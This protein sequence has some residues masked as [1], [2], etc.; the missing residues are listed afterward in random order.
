MKMSAFL[1]ALVCPLSLLVLTSFAT[2]G[3]TTITQTYYWRSAANTGERAGLAA[4]NAWLK[5]N[6]PK[7]GFQRSKLIALD[8]TSNLN[9]EGS[10]I[11]LLKFA[12]GSGEDVIWTHPDSFYL[13][14]DQD[15]FL[16]LNGFIWQVREGKNGE[17]LRK[18]D[19]TWD[20]IL[21]KHGKRQLLY[22]DWDKVPPISKQMFMRGDDVLGIPMLTVTLGFVWRKDVFHDA[23]LDPDQG[24]R[25]WDDV[26]NESLQICAK[27]PSS[28]P[29]YG[30]LIERNTWYMPT[31]TMGYGAQMVKRFK[32]YGDGGKQKVISDLAHPIDR[33]PD[34]TDLTDVPDRWVAAFDSKEFLAGVRMLRKLALAKW[35]VAPN[36]QPVVV[37]L[38]DDKVDINVEGLGH[39]NYK[40]GEV[41]FASRTY[42]Q[43][44]VR[45]GVAYVNIGAQATD[46]E[47]KRL[48]I[49]ERRI[50]MFLN[51]PDLATEAETF[52]LRNLGLC[53][54]P[55]GPKGSF[56]GIGG[57]FGSLN[58]ALGKDWRKA[59]LAWET[60]AYRSSTQFKLRMTSQVVREGKGLY[61]DPEL[62]R[63]G[64][65]TS[66]LEQVPPEMIT[67]RKEIEQSGYP[68]P[69]APEWD[70][71]ATKFLLP[72]Y[73]RALKD[74]NADYQK[75][76]KRAAMLINR[77]WQFAAKDFSGSRTI[78]WIGFAVALLAAA[79]IGG[80]WVAFRSLAAKYQLASEKGNKTGRVGW[81]TASMLVAPAALLVLVF[82]YYPIS[83]GLVLAFKDYRIAGG[84]EWVGLANFLELTRSDRVG[85]TLVTSL[86]YLIL[87]VGLGFF[88][89]VIL[90]VLL[91]E[92]PRGKVFFRTIYYLPATISG[93]VMALLWKRLLDPT[94]A[95]ILNQLLALVHIPPQTWLQSSSLAMPTIILIGIWGATGPGT[96]IYLAA[97]KS[98][99]DELY[100][101]AELDGANWR[102]RLTTITLKYLRPLLVI[103][104][105]GAVIGAFQAS[106]N[107][108]VLTGGGPDFATQTFALE[109]FMQ[110]F[111]FLK[112]GYAAAMA[113]VMATLLIAFTIWQLRILR[114]V[115]FRR[116]EVD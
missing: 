84:S 67:A 91:T 21:D 18:S 10:S 95:G 1:R 87:S 89:P 2:A 113:W 105:V 73:E 70:R 74:E 100:E 25:T 52:G 102:V 61:E 27:S 5:E 97:L 19:G 36:G 50:A 14:R 81:T 77:E 82:A 41:V 45:T 8:G 24:P 71:L 88:L 62:L 104:F 28:R 17:P 92:I 116:A 63:E 47:R 49:T 4:W 51:Y 110:A 22:K 37:H 23:G 106:Q 98:I 112:F 66:V 57:N 76:F 101:A 16:P 43:E 59:R 72:A 34:G 75:E 29:I 114:Q 68:E 86:Y 54:V 64:G 55:A 83:Q 115:E 33:A 44:E 38:P 9:I 35:I 53:R 103:N 30:F 107:I 31:L 78:S 3:P 69:Y 26:F 12:A 6:D 46:E 32:T 90:A 99:P 40:N 11:Q 108:F 56:G 48:L 85:H 96:L 111:I 80:A 58:S 94:P 42:K 93:I 7:T 65:F 79:C 109:I 39:G 15:L 60:L 13:F 20:Y